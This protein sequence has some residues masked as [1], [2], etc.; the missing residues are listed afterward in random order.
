MHQSL[1]VHSCAFFYSTPFSFLT[2]IHSHMHL[3]R[4]M[5]NKWKVNTWM[6]TCWADISSESHEAD[7]SAPSLPARMWLNGN[8]LF[9]FVLGSLQGSNNRALSLTLLSGSLYAKPVTICS[10]FVLCNACVWPLQCLPS[11]P[12]V[13]HLNDRYARAGRIGPSL[14][15]W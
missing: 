12:Q 13:E 8:A 11:C 2:C 9:A 14:L 15:F 4:Y 5:H 10:L 3:Y 6:Q 1:T 7:A